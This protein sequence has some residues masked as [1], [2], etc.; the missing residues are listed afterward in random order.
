MNGT[1]YTLAAVV[2][3]GY[4]AGVRWKDARRAGAF[5]A[6]AG[7]AATLALMVEQNA[8]PRRWRAVFS[9]A[10]SMAEQGVELGYAMARAKNRARSRS[11]A[12]RAMVARGHTPRPFS[13]FE[14][15]GWG[16]VSTASCRRCY[17]SVAVY[18][19]PAP[20]GARMIGAA[21]ANNCPAQ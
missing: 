8:Y 12:R 10:A 13:P 14:G 4:A 3:A 15:D 16:V 20:N 11:D 1:R 17:G 6:D 19:Y 21:L 2:A 5:S 7:Q 18:P 9:D